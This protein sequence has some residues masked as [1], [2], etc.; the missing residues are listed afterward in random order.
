MHTHSTEIPTIYA[1]LNA[2]VGRRV[3]QLS[4]FCL[5]CHSSSEYFS[6]SNIQ[7]TVYIKL[8][9][10]EMVLNLTK[11]TRNGAGLKD[12]NPQVGVQLGDL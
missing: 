8:E 3:L 2:L 5:I 10:P 6:P 7:Y 12:K 11:C 9:L 1:I 4:V